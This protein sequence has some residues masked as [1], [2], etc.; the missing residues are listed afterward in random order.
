MFYSFSVLSGLAADVLAQQSL[1][2]R[3]RA[4]TGR[5][6]ELVSQHAAQSPAP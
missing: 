4:R 2:D 1:V 5:R 6:P 3:S